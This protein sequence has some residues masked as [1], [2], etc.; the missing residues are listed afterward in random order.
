MG[1]LRGACVF[2]VEHTINH[3]LQDYWLSPKV[4]PKQTIK[5][6]T[7]TTC[8]RKY[9]FINTKAAVEDRTGQDFLINQSI[10][11]LS[12][13][14]LPV[15]VQK[16]PCVAAVTAYTELISPLTVIEVKI[17]TYNR[18]TLYIMFIFTTTIIQILTI[19][20]KIYYKIFLHFNL[21]TLPCLIRF[22][23]MFNKFILL[24]MIPRDWEIR[25]VSN[26]SDITV[27][28]FWHWQSTCEQTVFKVRSV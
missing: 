25:K 3:F 2:V 19:I 9:I 28:L 4:L 23:I 26:I 15:S 18:S 13:Y 20:L 8:C 1:S 21:I 24:Q 12:L 17:S 14:F 6:I 16:Q 27:T 7:H 11:S 5:L 10:Y 22:Q